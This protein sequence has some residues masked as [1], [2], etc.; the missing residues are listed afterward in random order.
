MHVIVK[1]KCNYPIIPMKGNHIFVVK[2]IFV[3]QPIRCL[4]LHRRGN[5]YVSQSCP[6]IMPKNRFIDLVTYQRLT[7]SQAR[8]LQHG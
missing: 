6:E 1:R 4:I 8:I 5:E 7:Q 3:R 2:R